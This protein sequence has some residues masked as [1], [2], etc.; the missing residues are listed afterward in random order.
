MNREAD[1]KLV[2]MLDA[3]KLIRHHKGYSQDYVRSSTGIDI[4][5]VENGDCCP[6]IKNFDILCQQ[7][8]I[9]PGWLWILNDYVERGE[10]PQQEMED[11]LMNWDQYKEPAKMLTDC[12]L[13]FF[14]KKMKGAARR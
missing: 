5:R 2:R 14:K 13:S 4:S 9:C 6:G 1:N 11:I 7:Y 3:L 10:L 8:D 12:F